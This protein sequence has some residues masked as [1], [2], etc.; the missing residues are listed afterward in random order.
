[1]TRA[2]HPFVGNLEPLISSS[3]IL[4]AHFT[5]IST[6]MAANEAPSQ[7]SSQVLTNCSLFVNIVDFLSGVPFIVAEYK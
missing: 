5:R 1:M 3:F 7:V 4:R 2:L 6:S